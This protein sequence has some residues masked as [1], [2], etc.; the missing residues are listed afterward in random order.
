M[1]LP[2]EEICVLKDIMKHAGVITFATSPGYISP[3]RALDLAK[4]LLD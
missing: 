2:K 4:A 3:F 1:A